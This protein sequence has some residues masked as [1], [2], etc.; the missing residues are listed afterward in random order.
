MEQP[1]E[2]MSKINFG[3][4]EVYNWRNEKPWIGNSF[5]VI[6]GFPRN[7]KVI[8]QSKAISP[9]SLIGIIGGYIGLFLGTIYFCSDK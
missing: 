3:Y 5:V 4:T 8:E 7:V 2:E 1:C 6:V 9:N